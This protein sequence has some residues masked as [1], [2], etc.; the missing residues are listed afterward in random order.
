[1]IQSV[2]FYNGPSLIGSV[3]TPPYQYSWSGVPAGSYA[4]TAQ[5]F[6]NTNWTVVSATNNITVTAPSLGAAAISGIVGNSLNYSGGV[7]SQF[8]LLSTNIVTAPLA[9]WTRL[10]TNTAASGSFTIP[11][12]SEARAFYT[13]KSE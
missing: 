3:T 11:V 2:A 12:G 4:F 1:M 10:A 9:N 5:V 6:Y 13:I 8:V 7:G